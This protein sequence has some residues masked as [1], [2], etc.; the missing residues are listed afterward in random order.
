[1]LDRIIDTIDKRFI[2]KDAHDKILDLEL[3]LARIQW[4]RE[5]QHSQG[6]TQKLTQGNERKIIEKTPNNDRTTETGTINIIE[7]RKQHRR[8]SKRSLP[9]QEQTI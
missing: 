5:A 7:A 3:R 1:M 9:M 6:I 4:E 2:S 8:Q